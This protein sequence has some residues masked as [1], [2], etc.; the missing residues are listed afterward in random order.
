MI[1][2]RVIKKYA[3]AFLSTHIYLKQF[4]MIHLQTIVTLILRN[5][6]ELLKFKNKVDKLTSVT[7]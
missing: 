2:E 4:S 3:Q 1:L 5:V 7:I 6:Y